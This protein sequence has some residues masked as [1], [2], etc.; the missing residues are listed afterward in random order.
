MAL[1]HFDPEIKFQP[2]TYVLVSYYLFAYVCRRVGLRRS[3][4]TFFM[5]L[6]KM[7]V[8]LKKMIVRSKVSFFMRSKAFI[9][10][11]IIVQETEKALGT[12]GGHYLRGFL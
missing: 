11:C 9:K 8:R 1:V 5:G 6:K 2:D 10:Y 3:K 7:I 4:V 12:L